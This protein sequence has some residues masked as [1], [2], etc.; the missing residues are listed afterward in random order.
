M[1][2]DNYSPSARSAAPASSAHS[3]QTA[4]DRIATQQH[5]EPADGRAADRRCITTPL[6][7][8][9][10]FDGS[11]GAS[12]RAENV[13]SGPRPRRALV[14]QRPCPEAE[15]TPTRPPAIGPR[16]ARSRR[17]ASSRPSR[18][19]RRRGGS[20][21]E[22]AVDSV[23]GV[24]TKVRRREHAS[25]S[26]PWESGTWRQRRGGRRRR[27]RRGWK[28]PAW[29]VSTAEGTIGGEG[30]GWGLHECQRSVWDDGE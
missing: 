19:R 3:P 17:A 16:P 27:S 14:R 1:Q 20:G 25:C 28:G 24:I 29:C 26:R 22:E 23:E 15:G 13:K 11:D 4:A 18:S 30:S 2:A 5:D 6:H 7:Q 9:S 8:R 10:G 12:R 21:C